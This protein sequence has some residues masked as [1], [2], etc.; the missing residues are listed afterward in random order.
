MSRGT[1]HPPTGAAMRVPVVSDGRE[2]K[3]GRLHEDPLG[4]G[5]ETMR[6]LGYRTVDLLVELARRTPTRRRSG[7]RRRRRCA[8]RLRGPAPDAPEPFERDP[9]RPRSG[10]PP[11]REPRA[12]TRGFFAFIPGVR[13]LARRARRLDRERAERLRGLVDGGGRPEPGRARG[14]RL[15]QASGSAIP[16]DGGRGARQRRLG[17]EHDRARVRARGA[18]RRPMT[19]RRRRL[20]LRPGALVA[21]ARGAACSASGPT[22]CACCPVD[23]RISARAATR[24]RPRST[25]TRGAGRRPLFVVGERRA[26]RTPARSTRCRELAAVCRERGVVAAR[27]RGVRR[28]RRAD[29]ARPQRCS[30][31]RAGRLDHAR[32][33]QVAVP[34][35]RVRLPARAR[36]R[37]AAAARS[38]SRPT[39]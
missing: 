30:R 33:A 38:R 16:A 36:R 13:H 34:A 2:W 15:V 22:R 23:G 21:R 31:H 27:R 25:P 8:A 24:S 10:R 3:D 12:T 9:R 32:P 6:E 28:V 11:V 26:R 39:T 20:R 17:G 35:V 19:R 14:A 5:R 29:R 37:A 4:V 18:R 1:A 7:G